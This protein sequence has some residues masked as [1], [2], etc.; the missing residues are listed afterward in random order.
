VNRHA[1][2]RLNSHPAAGTFQPAAII[3]GPQR[4]SPEGRLEESRVGGLLCVGYSVSPPRALHVPRV[5]KPANAIR[6]PTRLFCDHLARVIGHKALPAASPA[7]NVRSKYGQRIAGVSH[8]DD[9]SISSRNE[10]SGTR[11][12]K[13]GDVKKR[14]TRYR[15]LGRAPLSQPQLL[16][17]IRPWRSLRR[18]TAPANRGETLCPPAQVVS[19]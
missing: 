3:S 12:S 6:K 16:P 5:E 15:R 14:L 17:R 18:V 19:G 1:P 11:S 7:V 8:R 4:R 2:T 9:K 13:T 10:R